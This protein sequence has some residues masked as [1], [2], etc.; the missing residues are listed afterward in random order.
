MLVLIFDGFSCLYTLSHFHPR[1]TSALQTFEGHG[2]G[3]G[4]TLGSGLKGQLE[5]FKLVS[6]HDLCVLSLEWRHLSAFNGQGRS[7]YIDIVWSELNHQDRV[8][9]KDKLQALHSCLGQKVKDKPVAASVHPL[10]LLFL[11]I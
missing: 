6:K 11:Y 4:A 3:F 5:Y 1:P 7:H 8:E 10:F 2:C 9:C